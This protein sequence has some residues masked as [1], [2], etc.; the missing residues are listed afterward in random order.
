MLNMKN[1]FGHTKKRTENWDD[2]LDEEYESDWEM[3]GVDQEDS[4]ED[5]Y[6]DDE[7]RLLEG[8]DAEYVEAC[9][10]GAEGIRDDLGLD[11]S[12][13]T[14]GQ[15]PLWA[16]RGG[17]APAGEDEDYVPE[18]PSLVGRDGESLFMTESLPNLEET[19]PEEENV[20]AFSDEFG[21]DFENDAYVPGEEDFVQEP[22]PYD[23]EETAATKVIGNINEGRGER[24]QDYYPKEIRYEED[25]YDDGYDDEDD[26]EAEIRERRSN[27]VRKK[28]RRKSMNLIDGV[29]AM[30]GVAVLLLAVFI[31]VYLWKSS[32]KED[33]TAQF[34]TVGTQIQGIEKIGEKGIEA[35]AN[36][37]IAR[38][39]ANNDIDDTEID[40][41]TEIPGY[42]ENDYKT[43]VA[44]GMTLTSVQRDLKIKFQNRE[45][46]KLI[47]NVRF[48]AEIKKPD[49]STEEWVDSDMDGIIYEKD[50]ADGQY[51]ISLKALNDSKYSNYIL[52]ASSQ[53]VTVKRNI[54]Y[55]KVDVN[56]EVKNENE[57][58]ANVED[59]KRQDTAEEST[60]SDTVTWIS[61]TAT[62][63]TYTE[64][65]KSAIPD[66][67]TRPISLAYGF[68]RVADVL[69]TEDTGTPPILP[70]DTTPAP[71]PTDPTPTP[72][73]AA[74]PE[75]AP[76]PTATPVPPAV[77]PIP[78]PE[79]IPGPSTE[80][81]TAVATSIKIADRDK[82][83]EMRL[84]R[85]AD[86]S[87]T[88]ESVNVA[89][90]LD[91]VVSGKEIEFKAISSND[92]VATAA[93]NAGN[94][95][96][97]ITGRSVGNARITLM[98]DYKN[99][100]DRVAGVTNSMAEINVY[101]SEK[102]GNLTLSLDKSEVVGY[103][104]APDNPMVVV[105][106]IRNSQLKA[107]QI[108]ADNIRP[109]LSIEID[110]SIATVSKAEY[111]SSSTDGSADIRLSITPAKAF[112][113]KKSGVLVLK[114]KEGG[115]QVSAQCTYTVKPHPKYD[116]T[117]KLVDKDN[118][119][120]YVASE[121]Q[122]NTYREAV[123]AD[124]YTN[125]KFFVQ[126]GVTYTGWQTIDGKVY[127]FN[128]E[129]RPVTGEQVI[130]GAKYTFGSDGALITSNGVMG[131]DVS[132]WNGTIDWKAVK[133]S[134]V[135]FVIIR[136]GY[137]GSSGGMLVEDKKF[138][139]NIRGASEAGLKVGVYFFTQAIDE[140]EAVYEA[141]YVLEK[142]KNYKITYPVFLDVEASGGRGDRISKDMRTKVCKAF[143][144]TIQNAGYTAGVY[145]NKTWLNEKINAGELSNYKIWLAQYAAIPTYTGKYDM[146]QYK[147][148]GTVSG[149]SGSVDMDLSYM[150]F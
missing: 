111:L 89:V 112:T 113:E 3:E 15:I 94:G 57:I 106:S 58:D 147:C 81:P 90:Q 11:G 17:S 145:A 23:Y 130:Q 82:N 132:K 127:Y 40:A 122:A 51:V 138:T 45:T 60:L 74:T 27:P 63:N 87:Y 100:G 12:V 41:S 2:L 68:M 66:P 119:Q 78:N 70:E 80:V 1:I 85:A 88:A 99:Q 102:I 39:A 97:T 120:L 93:V 92:Q 146:W 96:V 28:R 5:I 59:T 37:E 143:C 140:V 101:I 35:V 110:E 69:T 121:T 8:M 98:L 115:E 25:R 128:A 67:L 141:S 33:P 42:E 22:D 117:T 56:G 9:L 72:E 144:Q 150:G 30:T 133:S 135:Y 124:Y 20:V 14:D 10:P 71:Q 139:A 142:I 43:T 38:I 21:D 47:G 91:G 44:V 95:S 61:S 52:P 149:I 26:I 65:L 86:G 131:I 53:T 62:G 107:S 19:I 7:A 49:G 64:V 16:R 29:I 34:L 125:V 46:S 134:G 77:T 84:R 118:R 129:G 73:P 79:P 108:T 76:E 31:G 24:F 104:E 136:C 137:R 148:T 48:V 105:A 18:E 54:E 123:Y 50:I 55:K 75:P 13:R 6:E 116:R 114:Y 103:C 4:E 109:N 83:I 36:A 126:G 32:H